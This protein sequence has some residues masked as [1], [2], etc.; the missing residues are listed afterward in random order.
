MDFQ[1]E[2]SWK[3]VLKEEFEKDYMKKLD[4]FLQAQ[5]DKGLRIFPPKHLIFNAFNHTP[6]KKVRV[7]ILGQDPYH[8]INQAHGLA[9]SVSKG[10][11][12]PPSLKNIFKELHLEYPD[13]KHPQH[14]DLSHWA[15]QGVLLLNATLTVEE[16]KAGSHQNQG[17]EMF[18]DK[19]IQLLSE[20]QTGIIFLLWGKYAQAKSKLINLEK[21]VVLSAA[22]PSPLSAYNGFLGCNHFIKTNE[23][24]KQ[25]GQPEINWQL[26]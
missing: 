24:L 15:N 23:I 8:G 4:C 11:T 9:F 20:Q 5:E 14:G 1:I 12:I 13:F 21:H 16:S 3:H 26:N 6:F 17:W 25:A 10:I 22:H 2:T 7:L 18:T 19:V